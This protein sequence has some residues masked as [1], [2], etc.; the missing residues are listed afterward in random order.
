M[1]ADKP[2]LPLG[3]NP[4]EFASSVI[5]VRMAIC[6][7]RNSPCACALP[8]QTS[9]RVEKWIPPCL[10][11]PGL[12]ITGPY[13]LAI[14][15]QVQAR[16]PTQP[17]ETQKHC[18]TGDKC[19]F[20]PSISVNTALMLDLFVFGWCFFFLNSFLGPIHHLCQKKTIR[21]ME[22]DSWSVVFCCAFTLL[23]DVGSDTYLHR[24]A[25]VA[26]FNYSCSTCLCWCIWFMIMDYVPCKG[27][28]LVQRAR[29]YGV[30]N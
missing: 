18:K 23:N 26:T 19:G 10:R 21:Q 15:S 2:Y 6:N 4:N 14:P 29:S 17:P 27:T 8:E 22:S 5:N 11:L 28:Y 16:L 13:N 25:N 3:R 7:P 24:S 12:L 1:S 9:S 20:K 30:S